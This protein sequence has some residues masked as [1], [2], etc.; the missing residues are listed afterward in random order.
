[1]PCLRK[2]MKNC[3]V[4]EHSGPAH[5]D[6][7]DLTGSPISADPTLSAWIARPGLDRGFNDPLGAIRTS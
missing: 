7:R 4:G 6:N 1:M 2:G 3:H 5:V